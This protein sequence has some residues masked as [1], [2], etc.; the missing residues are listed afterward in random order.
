MCG[1]IRRTLGEHWRRETQL[2]FYKTMALSTLLYGS[3]EESGDVQ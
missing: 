3:E 2:K 1:T